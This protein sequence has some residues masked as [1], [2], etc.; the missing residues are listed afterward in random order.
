[1]WYKTTYGYTVVLIEICLPFPGKL[2]FLLFQTNKQT[3][4]GMIQTLLE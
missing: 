1:M 4:N 3:L 2:D